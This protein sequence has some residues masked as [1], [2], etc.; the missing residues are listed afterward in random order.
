ML[1]LLECI[2]VES[3]KDKKCGI[4]R[5]CHVFMKVHFSFFFLLKV[6]DIPDRNLSI[7]CLHCRHRRH[8]TLFTFSSYSPEPLGQ[9]Q[10]NLAQGFLK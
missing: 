6:H 2:P 10:L 9:F 8:H 4:D 5:V 1:L 3:I 7:V